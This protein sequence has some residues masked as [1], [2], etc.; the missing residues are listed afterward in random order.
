MTATRLTARHVTTYRYTEPA[1]Q[2]Q[3]HV[4]LTPRNSARQR[5]IDCRLEIEPEPEPVR[6]HMDYF[7]NAVQSFRVTHEHAKLVIVATSVAELEPLAGFDFAATPAWE[8]LKDY[9]ERHSNDDAFEAAQFL[10]DSPR[11]R[12]ST[13]LAD[14]ARPVFTPGRPVL[15]SAL[16][17]NRK[18]H[19]EFK[20]DSDSTDV[21]TPVEA[22]LA[23]RTGVCQDFA[24]VMAGSLRSL[25]VPSRY[26][27]GY[28]KSSPEFVGTEASHA[29]VSVFCPGHGWIDFDPTNDLVPSL[30]HVTL[31]WGRDYGDV[32]PV[33]GITLGGGDQE[34]EVGVGVTGEL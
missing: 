30:G 24:H 12:R 7:G 34:I 10:Y 33:K 2:C 4:R 19:R 27:S 21:D 6:L 28:L 15:E 25:G 26:V 29:W 8:T 9:V 17:L 5:L 31:A 23:R 3:N 11:V 16:A 1:L 18:I 13:A 32:P 14:F 22:A 20:Y